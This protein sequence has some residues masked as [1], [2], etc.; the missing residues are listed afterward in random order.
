MYPTLI[1]FSTQINEMKR[2]Y[3]ISKEQLGQFASDHKFLLIP[4]FFIILR[5]G[6]VVFSVLY[7]YTHLWQQMSHTWRDI[8][9]YAAV[10]LVTSQSSDLSSYNLFFA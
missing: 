7:V 1:L 2:L 3:T 9:F 6:S 10:S 4:L 5:I 8:V